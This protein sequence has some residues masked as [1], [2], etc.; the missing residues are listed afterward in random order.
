MNARRMAVSVALAAA[1]I[2]GSAVTA[3]AATPAPCSVTNPCHKSTGP[4]TVKLKCTWFQRLCHI[5][6]HAR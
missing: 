3:E 2:A 4:I 5:H 1:L 6:R